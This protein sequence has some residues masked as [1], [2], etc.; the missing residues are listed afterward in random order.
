VASRTIQDFE[1]RGELTLTRAMPVGPDRLLTSVHL[2]A[3]GLERAGDTTVDTVL[4]GASL[5]FV[6]P[7]ENDVAGVV[8]G[9]GFEWR[10]REGASV[11]GAAEA[12]GFSDQSTVWSARGGL[13]V[14]F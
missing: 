2:G 14:A 1:E 7:G 4:L 8:G 3:I 5:P 9:G 6:T 13:R 12:I 11:F 10:T